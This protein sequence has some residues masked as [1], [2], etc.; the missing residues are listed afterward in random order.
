[1]DT[2]NDFANPITVSPVLVGVPMV[3]GVGDEGQEQILLPDIAAIPAEVGT[4][5]PDK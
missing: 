2:G 3:V 4:L 1:L 5:D